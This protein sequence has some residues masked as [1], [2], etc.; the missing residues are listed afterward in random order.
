MITEGFLYGGSL[1][2]ALLAF[3]PLSVIASRNQRL[4]FKTERVLGDQADSQHSNSLKIGSHSEVSRFSSGCGDQFLLLK[5]KNPGSL[6][7]GFFV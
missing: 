4:A 7:P 2:A 5:T 6:T 1:I 3:V